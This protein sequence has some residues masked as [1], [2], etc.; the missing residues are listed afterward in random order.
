[1]PLTLPKRYSLSGVDLPH[2]LCFTRP[3]N[4]L[5]C[6]QPQAPDPQGYLR[7]SRWLAAGWEPHRRV[8]VS[9]NMLLAWL[10]VNHCWQLPGKTQAGRRHVTQL[11][12]DSTPCCAGWMLK[13]VCTCLSVWKKLQHLSDGCHPW[14]VHCA[15]EEKKSLDS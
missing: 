13:Q 8:M 9:T 11:L 1:M 3:H 10:P 12:C 2:C 14:H 5:H 7:V 4:C 6:R 15:L